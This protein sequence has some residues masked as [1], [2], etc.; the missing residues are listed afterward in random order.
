VSGGGWGSGYLV[1]SSAE[2]IQRN[3]QSHSFGGQA[4]PGDLLTCSRFRACD[5]NIQILAWCQSAAL[6]GSSDEPQK[7][8]LAS[9]IGIWAERLQCWDTP[10]SEVS[11]SPM[12]R[13]PGTCPHSVPPGLGWPL[14]SCHLD[15]YWGGD[16]GP[17]PELHR[18]LEISESS[19]SQGRQAS[20]YGY[21][22]Q[23]WLGQ[24]R[25]PYA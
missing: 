1:I 11:S 3:Y 17:A 9:L 10:T 18:N 20:A 8:G 14:C 4:D 12:T 24:D 19:I 23:S 22:N 6:G 15:I 25:M 7:E 21:P 16:P 2:K 13:L 5:A